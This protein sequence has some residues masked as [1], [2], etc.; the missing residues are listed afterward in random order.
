MFVAQIESPTGVDIVEEL[1]QIDGLD[2]IMVAST[3]LSS[4]SGF[5]QGDE[6]YESMVTKVYDATLSNGLKLGGPYAWK[7]RKGFSFFQGPDA[8]SILRR[9]VKN[10]LEETTDGLAETKGNEK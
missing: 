5:E 8:A 9:G 10:I 6:K 3:D 1:T 7:E 2:I 4:F